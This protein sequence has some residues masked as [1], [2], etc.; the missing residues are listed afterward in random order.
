[1]NET[2][3]RAHVRLMSISD[4]NEFVSGLNSDGTSDRYT[5]ENFAGT[6]RINARSMQGMIYASVDYN[7]EMYLVNET[8]DGVFPHIIDKF[9]V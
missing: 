8:Q 7:E 3:V 2:H 5:I 9:R 1:M 4:I 6:L